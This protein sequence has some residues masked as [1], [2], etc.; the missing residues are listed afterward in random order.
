MFFIHF[1]SISLIFYPDIYV[2][3]NAGVWSAEKWIAHA[4]II[5][6]NFSLIVESFLLFIL[7]S[8]SLLLSCTPAR[9]PSHTLARSSSHT[10]ALPQSCTL[11]FSILRHFALFSFFHSLVFD[12]YQSKQS[13]VKW[14]CK[15]C[16]FPIVPCA[17]QIKSDESL[18]F[19]CNGW[20]FFVCDSHLAEHLL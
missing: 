1:E 13:I 11:A 20:Y 9:S 12:K 16:G 18:I 6:T 5:Q 2:F 3:A 17:E 8:L 14:T 10:L 15:S 4:K 19:I 7:R